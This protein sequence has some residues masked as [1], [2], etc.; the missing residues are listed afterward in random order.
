VS[1]RNYLL[2]SAD[3]TANVL[4]KSGV[5][6]SSKIP[7]FGHVSGR[8]GRAQTNK[9]E[10]QGLWETCLVE[11]L[12]LS[13]MM[14]VAAV[15]SGETQGIASAWLHGGRLAKGPGRPEAE[16][17]RADIGVHGPAMRHR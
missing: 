5:M 6:T 8:S 14:R 3:K 2:P 7:R 17:S 4:N 16:V 11:R 10:M 1:C 15:D 9:W 12:L 13:I